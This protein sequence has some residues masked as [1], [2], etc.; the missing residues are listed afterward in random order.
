MQA[1]EFPV[2]YD[3]K[4]AGLLACRLG[5][6]RAEI[7]NQTVS[8]N[9]S[10]APSEKPAA[11]KFFPARHKN[12]RKGESVLNFEYQHRQRANRKSHEARSKTRAAHFHSKSVPGC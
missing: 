4:N 10:P 9:I 8:G 12:R 2:G 1:L 5:L 3:E 7:E 6:D 11:A